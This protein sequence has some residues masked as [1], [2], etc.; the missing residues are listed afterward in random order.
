MMSLIC[1]SDLVTAV[2]PV[3]FW[4][5]LPQGFGE[6]CKNKI[7]E[8]QLPDEVSAGEALKA[9]CAAPREMGALPEDAKAWMRWPSF[10]VATIDAA[11]DFCNQRP[12]EVTAKRSAL[13][14][15]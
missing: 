7:N 9:D 6:T 14:D 1:C 8:P 15:C 3:V 13:V 2:I 10:R 12:L 11:F 4:N 5:V